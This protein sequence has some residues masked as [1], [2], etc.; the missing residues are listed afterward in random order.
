MKKWPA[1]IL[2]ALLS[3]C[4]SGLKGTYSDENGMF[5]YTFNSN[6]KVVVETM[7]MGTEQEY[8]VEDG[9]VKIASPQGTLVMN[10][11]DDGSI[12]G[13]MGMKLTKKK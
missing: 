10:I 12:A 6:G 11:L 3:A 4:G 2:V 8:K 7:G 9:K 5:S 13:P 1:I